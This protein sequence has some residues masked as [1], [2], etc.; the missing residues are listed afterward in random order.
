MQLNR[1]LMFF[2]PG[3]PSEFRRYGRARNPA[4]SARAFFFTTAAGLSAFNYLW[5][6]CKAIVKP[7]STLQ[8]P[9][10][11]TNG[12]SLFNADYRTETHRTLRQA[13]NR[14][15]KPWLDVKTCCRTERDF[16]KAPKDCPR[17]SSAIYKPPVQ[18]DVQ[19]AIH[20]WFIGF[21]TFSARR[22]IAGV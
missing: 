4:A 9:P 1:C 6:F 14:R 22:R 8:L 20:R 18:P 16:L 12:L 5:S 17:R 10:G 11:V 2:T 13:S 21:A 15:W 7:G 19:R 3:V